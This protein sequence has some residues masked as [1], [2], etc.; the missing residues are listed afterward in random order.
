MT[1]E[2]TFA[3]PRPTTLER[4]AAEALSQ[5]GGLT[6]DAAAILLGWLKADETLL[7]EVIEDA[8]GSAVKSAVRVANSSNRLAIVRRADSQGNAR[9]RALATG[10]AASLLDFPLHGGVRVRDAN[11]EQIRKAIRFYRKQSDENQ[12]RAAWLTRVLRVTPKQGVVG[13]VL[14]EQQAQRLWEGVST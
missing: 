1:T 6:A 12:R 5:S 10:L 9:V 8:V 7:A 14:D 2:P 11:R 13:D 4:L 3:T